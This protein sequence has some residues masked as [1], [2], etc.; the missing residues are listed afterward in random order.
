[1]SLHKIPKIFNWSLYKFT[2][3]ALVSLRVKFTLIG[4]FCPIINEKFLITPGVEG[5]HL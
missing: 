2:L 1:M 3:S 5:P 4:H